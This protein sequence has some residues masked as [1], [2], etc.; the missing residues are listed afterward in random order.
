M[1]KPHS[2]L[3]LLHAAD[4]LGGLTEQAAKDKKLEIRVGRFPFVGNGKAI[5]LGEDQ[6]WSK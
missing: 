3:H 6:G 1:D 5:A 4:R 2:R